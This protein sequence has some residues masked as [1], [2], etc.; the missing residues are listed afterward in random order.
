MAV[1]RVAALAKE[2]ESLRGKDRKLDGSYASIDHV[3]DLY[4]RDPERWRRLAPYYVGQTLVTHAGAS[5][6]S[7]AGKDAGAL[8]LTG[9]T[10]SPAH[11]F[12]PDDA[13]KAFAPKLSPGLLRD[14]TERHDLALRRQ[15]VAELERGAKARL[16][17]LRR[18][19]KELT[20]TDPGP[21][22]GE[23]ASLDLVEQALKKSR[24]AGRDVRRRV[25][26]ATVLYLGVSLFR[27][28]GRSEAWTV[29]DEDGNA[30]FGEAR[31]GRWA[32]IVVVRN[33]GPKSAPGGLRQAVER[34]I[35]ARRN[36]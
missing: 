13:V 25:Q 19:T 26:T 22:E 29:C 1:D 28:T 27:G 18:D 23:P 10:E 8:G 34:M 11:R 6:F 16:A 7:G 36:P 9:F 3:E 33:T 30:D 20:G 24:D 12:F 4:A 5:W 2:L 31:L 14:F 35:S 17:E 32:P 21:L 15:Q